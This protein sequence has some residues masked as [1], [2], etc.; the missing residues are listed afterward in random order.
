MQSVKVIGLNATELKLFH[1]QGPGFP[2]SHGVVIFMFSKL[3][4]MWIFGGI[5]DNHC[6]N[7]L[8]IT[9]TKCV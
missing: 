8:F 1:K 9:N 5:V 7:F 4:E 6:L 2:T 3:R